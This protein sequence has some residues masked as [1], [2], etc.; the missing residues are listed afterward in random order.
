MFNKSLVSIYEKY[1][2]TISA[3]KYI[4]E[5]S[6]SNSLPYHGITHTFEVFEACANYVMDNPEQNIHAH[7]LLIAA[8]FH[9]FNHSG[10]KLPDSENVRIAIDGM[11]QFLYEKNML[12]SFDVELAAYVIMAT[13][14]PY[15]LDETEL[16]I[17]GRII[18]DADMYQS[19][20]NESIVKLYYGLRT[21]INMSME[22]FCAM[23]SKFL[24]NMK[25][26]TEYFRQM[27]SQVCQDRLIELELLKNSN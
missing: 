18:R 22:D 15:V 8:L 9:D 10:G 26:N 6:N 17:E 7:E 23:E 4:I 25:L 14:F 2:S 24:G 3:I 11:V 21:E 20:K 5:N 13:Q 12:D 27:W 19:M 16:N 1:P